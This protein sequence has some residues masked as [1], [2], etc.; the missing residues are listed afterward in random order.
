[1]AIADLN[2]DG[3]PDLVVANYPSNTVSVL[4]NTTAP[5]AATPTFAPKVDFATGSETV[6]VAVADFNGD[7]KPD[8]VVANYGSNSVS[9]L[10]N[11]TTAGAATPS[12]APKVD[13]YTVSPSTVAVADFNGDGR[14]DIVTTSNTTSS[15]SVLLNTTMAGAATPTFAAKVDFTTG[16]KAGF[17]RVADLN[18][19]GKPDLVVANP[20][21]Q[22]RV[23]AAEHDD[24]GRDHAQLRPQGGLFHRIVSQH[25]G[26]RRP[27]RRRQARPR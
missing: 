25:R 1:V 7:G 17:V 27:Q 19:D 22:Q 15:V 2:G 6:Y 18:G 26:H 21:L 23:G 5:G 24:D 9:V 8:L 12:F 20:L 3:K 13:F 11:T 10:L 4:L 16:N 14:P